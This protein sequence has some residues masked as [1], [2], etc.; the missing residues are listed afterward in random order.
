MDEVGT[1]S[2][3]LIREVSPFQ[4]ANNTYLDEVGAWS[5]VLI[6][7]VLYTCRP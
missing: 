2:S 4:G 7:E 3:V 5:K 1:W 6:R